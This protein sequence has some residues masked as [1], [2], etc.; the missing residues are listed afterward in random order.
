MESNVVRPLTFQIT[1]SVSPDI[2]SLKY[3]RFTTLG[4]EDIGI[5]KSEFVAKTQFL[6][7]EKTRISLSYLQRQRFKGNLVNCLFPSLNERSL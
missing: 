2:I 1:T 6:L 3:Q 5:R 4:S 7:N